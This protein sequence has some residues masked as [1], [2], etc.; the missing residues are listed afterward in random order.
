[1]NEIKL[2]RHQEVALQKYKDSS[3]IPLFFDP[4]CGKTL[5]A[6]SIAANKFQ[7]GLIDAL[8]VIA[9]NGVHKQWAT[10]ELPK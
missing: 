4:G 2:F 10:E 7:R 1:M 8:L 9:P 3:E 5:T 6:L